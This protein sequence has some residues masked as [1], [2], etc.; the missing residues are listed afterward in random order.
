MSKLEFYQR[1]LV[2]FDPTN[3]EHRRWFAEYQKHRTW[4]HCPVRFIVPEDA[5]MDLPGMIMRQLLDYYV[6]KEF[7]KEQAPLDKGPAARCGTR[8]TRTRNG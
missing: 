1:Q 7:L 3:K 2:A 8:T 4:G 5:G 6:T